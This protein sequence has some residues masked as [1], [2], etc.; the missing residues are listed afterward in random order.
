MSVGWAG[1]DGETEMPFGTIPAYQDDAVIAAVWSLSGECYSVLNQQTP[2][3]LAWRLPKNDPI[4]MFRQ[5]GESG[6]L[7]PVAAAQLAGRLADV[8]FKLEESYRIL[9]RDMDY[10]ISSE[11][12]QLFDR[13]S[14]AVH[15]F[16]RECANAAAKVKEIKWG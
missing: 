10:W 6:H 14:H 3:Y 13:C 8:A 9:S 1:A 11:E 2:D 4:R 16:L 7:T 12:R 5:F 15:F